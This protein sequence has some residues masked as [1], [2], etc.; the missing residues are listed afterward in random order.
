MKVSELIELL[1]DS[2]PDK[3]VYLATQPNYPLA[4]KL[5]GVYDPETAEPWDEDSQP[6]D[7]DQTKVWLVEG[8]QA[9]NPYSVPR[10]A[11]DCYA[12]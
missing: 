8:S 3:E 6:R 5:R 11:F 2:D 10:D 7:E 12:S 9:P 1:S 4:F